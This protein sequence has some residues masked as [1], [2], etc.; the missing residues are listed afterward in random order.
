MDSHCVASI[1]RMELVS[2]PRIDG[3]I[4]KEMHRRK[5]AAARLKVMA[6]VSLIG[7][8]A[9]GA[10]VWFSDAGGGSQEPSQERASLSVAHSA[11]LK[12]VHAMHGQELAMTRLAGNA[13][14]VGGEVAGG[15]SSNGTVRMVRWFPYL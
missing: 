11:A 9:F 7:I 15:N 2:S 13:S 10:L 4:A 1:L 14:D 8:I 12:R 5:Q 3:G 6:G